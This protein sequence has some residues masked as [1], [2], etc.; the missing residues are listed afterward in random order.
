MKKDVIN[1]VNEFHKNG[2]LVKGI[3]RSFITL[4]PK[5]E[6]PKGLAKYRPISLVGSIYKIIAK[7]LSH[8]LKSVLP[9]VISETQS[10]FLSGGNILDGVL[11]AN[12]LVDM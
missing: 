12:E 6:N 4:I 2:K 3:N 9:S 5:K 1:F 7:L 8:M 11:I 10:A